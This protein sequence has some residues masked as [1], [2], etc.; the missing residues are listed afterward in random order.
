MGESVLQ[1]RHEPGCSGSS[2]RRLAHAQWNCSC[3]DGFP[4][5]SVMSIEQE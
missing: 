1:L 5:Q 2:T 3:A 4:V